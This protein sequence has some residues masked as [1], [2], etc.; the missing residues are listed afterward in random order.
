MGRLGGA[1]MGGLWQDFSYGLRTLAKNRGFALI[2]VLTLALGIGSSAAIFSV[3]D[4]VLF[5]PFPY[6]DSNRLLM[7]EIDDADQ[8]GADSRAGFTTPE[9]R[10]YYQHSAVF[11]SVIGHVSTDVLYTTPQGTERFNGHLITA[12]TFE[13]LGVPPFLGRATRPDDY[14]PAAPPVFVMRYKTWVSRFDADPKILNHVFDLNGTPRTLVGIM[15][16]RFAL[17]GAD[18]WI[19][20]PMDQSTQA[21]DRQ[22]PAYWQLIGRL[23]SGVSVRQAEAE[24]TLLAQ[25]VSKAYPA[26]YPKHFTVHVISLTQATVGDFRETLFI[27]LAAVGVL[28]LIA[29]GNVASLLLAR[30]TTREKEFAIR[31]ALGASRL[32]LVRQLLIE[33]LLL[34]SAGA[35]LGCLMA[36]VG[37]NALIAVIPQDI[38][39]EEAVITMNAPVLLFALGVAIFTAFV[40]GLAP[41]LQ[42]SRR[43]LNDPLRDSG[44][45]VNDGSRRLN[46]RNAVVAL[47]VALSLTLLVSAGLLMKSFLALRQVHL[48]LRPD[49][50]LVVRLPLPED[51]YKTAGQVHGFFRPLL[52]R[53]KSLP[54]VVDA[55]ETSA[56]PP[57]GGIPADADVSGKTH[58]EKWPT[59]FQLCS[60]GYFPTVGISFL[61]G[62]PFNESEVNSARKLAVVNQKFA[63]QFLGGDNPIGQRLHLPSLETWADPVPDAWFEIIG[64][65]ADAKNQGLQKPALPEV[66]IPYTVTGGAR[67]GLLVRTSGDPLMMMNAVRTEIWATDRSVALTMTGTLESYINSYSYSQPRFGFLLMGIFAA[68]G[69]ILVNI[70]VYSVIA[71]ATARRTHEIGIRMALGAHRQNILRLIVG[72]GARMAIAGVVLGVLVSF[73]L[74]R[75]LAS[76]LF[77]VKPSDPLIFAA[78]SALL[79]AV[80]LLACYI[81]ARRAMR[82]DPMVALHHD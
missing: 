15:P 82:V 70:G 26:D 13:M 7:I 35:V 46:L 68:V 45:G 10:D 81:P 9:F 69:L 49:H 2:A 23:K 19:P 39:P 21:M 48:G 54:G 42:I 77:E 60:E 34:A 33:S 20:D 43:D 29:C 67:R 32:R 66:W 31:S 73:A 79:L 76:L 47:E 38:L 78:V 53:V 4:H 64:V 22:F 72:Q 5:E 71:Y 59:L 28:L 11:D 24:L 1:S 30:A 61:Q 75:L 27:I 50:V 65:V 6:A 25:K 41:A 8:S 40:F 74:T 57:Y 80:T 44:K 55:A 52:L 63:H 18:L 58:S 12:G 3:I 56:L 36:S 17:G 14:K 51:R 16:P 62:R 37:L